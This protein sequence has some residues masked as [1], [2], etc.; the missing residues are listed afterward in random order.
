[1]DALVIADYNQA[2]MVQTGIAGLSVLNKSVEAPH[3]DPIGLFPIQSKF[4]YIPVN[5]PPKQLSNQMKPTVHMGLMSW[6]SWTLNGHCHPC[7]AKS[8]FLTH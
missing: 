7:Q 2:L 8:K 5:H 3:N 1:M 4:E 6:V